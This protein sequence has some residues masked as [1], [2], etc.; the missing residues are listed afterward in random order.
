MTTVEILVYL[1]QHSQQGYPQFPHLQG[2]SPIQVL[3]LLL[4]RHIRFPQ[5]EAGLMA[6]LQALPPHRQAPQPPA[7]RSMRRRPPRARTAAVRLHRRRQ[8][9]S[10]DPAGPQ[11]TDAPTAG[12]RS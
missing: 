2:Y 4:T 6:L 5:G 3:A 9:Q 1:Q 10:S 7:F 8:P 11:A 12:E